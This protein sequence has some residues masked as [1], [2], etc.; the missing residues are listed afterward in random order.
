MKHNDA[1]LKLPVS[2]VFNKFTGV[3]VSV[4]FSSSTARHGGSRIG[5]FARVASWTTY[6]CVNDLSVSTNSWSALVT[7][8]SCIYAS[9]NVFSR[10]TFVLKLK[11]LDDVFSL[12]IDTDIFQR[13]K[14]TL[15]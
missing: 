10:F 6:H 9:F 11:H 3:F 13:I 2:I 5:R 14:L 4:V 12:V 1:H 8:Y 7:I 15:H